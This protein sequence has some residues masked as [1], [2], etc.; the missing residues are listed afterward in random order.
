MK[1]TVAILFSLILLLQCSIR[2][3]IIAHFEI[4]KEYISENLCENRNKPELHC[5]GKCYLEK[6]LQKESNSIPLTELLKEKFEESYLA[7]T[8]LV[9]FS[10]FLD[11]VNH[12]SLYL[13]KVKLLFI[14]S[15]FH[16]PSVY[17]YSI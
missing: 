11:E 8:S 5:S 9:L 17:S 1:R 14:S 10:V 15:I 16:P 6:E 12:F 3:I 4:N 2:T 7:Q 13:F